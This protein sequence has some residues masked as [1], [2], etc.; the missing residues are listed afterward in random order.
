MLPPGALFEFKIHKNA[1][2][3]GASPRTS[4]EITELPDPLAGFQGADSRQGRGRWETRKRRGSVPPLLFFY[5]LTTA[6]Q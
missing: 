1:Y 2:A 3:A 5:N 6:Q 4:L